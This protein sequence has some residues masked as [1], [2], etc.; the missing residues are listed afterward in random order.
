MSQPV[1][2][3]LRGN[4]GSPF[5]LYKH[6]PL[7][8]GPYL[9]QVGRS[10]HFM[11][12]IKLGSGLCHWLKNQVGPGDCSARPNLAHEYPYPNPYQS[13]NSEVQT[14]KSIHPSNLKTFPSPTLIPSIKLK[15]FSFPSISPMT[16]LL[17]F[18]FT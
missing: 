8:I 12:L 18:K 6:Y 2:L 16:C 15:D 10:K 5:V 4:G 7:G 1:E 3:P 17:S 14:L 11:A 9:F 13:S